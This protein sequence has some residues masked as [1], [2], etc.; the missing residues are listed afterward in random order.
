[1]LETK[2]TLVSPLGQKDSLQEEM[3]THSSILALR[4]PWTEEPDR[5]HSTGSQRVEHNWATEHSRMHT[6][7]N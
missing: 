2:E 7:M 3:A 1:M 4:N 5:L 6:R